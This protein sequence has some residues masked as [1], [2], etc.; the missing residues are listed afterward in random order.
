MHTFL[1]DRLLPESEALVPVSDR[2]FMYGDGVF[3]TIRVHTGKTLRWFAHTERLLAGLEQ[4]GIKPPLTPGE[5]R[6]AV[7]EL[8]SKNDLTDG[9]VR[10]QVTRGSGQRG[11]SPKGADRPTLVITSHP[12]PPLTDDRPKRRLLPASLRIASD[13]PLNRI[14]SINKLPN[15]LAQ[16]EADNAGYDDAILLNER[17]EVAETACANLF[18]IRSGVVHTPPLASGALPG[19][20]R[21]FVTDLAAMGEIELTERT[22][23]LSDLLEAEGVFLTASSRVL[24]EVGQIG[25]QPIPHSPVYD[26]LHQGFLYFLN[27][28]QGLG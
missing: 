15:I 10:I 3:E 14:K 27:K 20:T 22:T 16:A 21:N 17:D 7:D 6:A 2:G 9:L 13:S 18:W 8:I 1:N 28:G 23:S 5:L 19:I 24:M 12:G 4:I 26:R 25:N 11:Y